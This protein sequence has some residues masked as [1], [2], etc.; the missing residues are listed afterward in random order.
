ME[1]PDADG[2]GA[3][4][5][6]S[7][8]GG[9][10]GPGVALGP[11]V[12]RRILRAILV[13]GSSMGLFALGSFVQD[14]VVARRFGA[15]GAVDAFV[16]ALVVPTFVAA[17]VA[18]A[19]GTAFLPAY[20]EVGER[21]GAEAGARLFSSVVALA[22]VL[23]VALTVAMALIAP[24]ALPVVTGGFDRETQ[25]LARSLFFILL[26]IIPLS[27]VAALWRATLNARERFAVAALTRTVVP[28]TAIVA[29]LVARSGGIRALAVG[30]VVGFALQ[31][32]LLGRTLR[33]AGLPIVPLSL[34]VDPAVRRV[35]AQ[36]KPMAWGA[37][38]MGTAPLLDGAMASRLD[39]GSVAAL[40]YGNRVPMVIIGI[41]AAA[42]GTAVF[43]YF[44]RLVAAGRWATVRRTFRTYAVI[45]AAV[46]VPL[47]A[48]LALSSEPLVRLLFERG[49]FGADDTDL[50]APVQ[51]LLALQL[52]FFL[53]SVLL[54]RLVAA[55]RANQ[56]L[57]WGAILNVSLNAVLNLVF[58]RWFGVAG[59]ALSTSVV[60]LFSSV[61]VGVRLARLLKERRIDR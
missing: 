42:L 58:M 39:E 25:A 3:Q 17:V 44:S 14:A 59:I 26:P 20:V 28:L 40:H 7:T 46:T 37:T 29:V 41:A 13:V 33:V 5:P 24:L 4:P 45:V 31:L 61:Y 43:P 21:D 56:I 11:S 8:I 50:V 15:G 22:G 6:G 38:I 53:V 30:T 47:A 36:V 34:G 9:R 49:A 16:L 23:L 10:S 12:N 54:T 35:F 51:A 55:C 52:P 18:D 2:S 1:A 48:V 60:Y 32:V 57:M 27:G 19:F